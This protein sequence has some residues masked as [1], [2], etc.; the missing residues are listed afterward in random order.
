MQWFTSD[1]HLWHR[2]ILRFS[3]TTRLCAN[4]DEMLDTLR[5]NWNNSV[6]NEDDVWILGDVSFGNP[7]DTLE[8]LRSLKGR[9]HLVLGNHDRM[10]EHDYNIMSQVLQSKQHYAELQLRDGNII[11]M[12]HYPMAVWNRCHHGSYH[13]YGHCH[14]AFQLEGRAM[15]VGLDSRSDL[16]LWSL[17]E[18]LIKLED[19]PYVKHY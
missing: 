11:V 13:L 16:M 7:L 17:P 3:Q 10:F 19:K 6:A 14:G 4:M 18:I 1:L 15:D 5:N 2:N 8:Y 12:S 9:K